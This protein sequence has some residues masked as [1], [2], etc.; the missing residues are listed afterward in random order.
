MKVESSTPAASSAAT[1]P[2]T[3]SSTASSA[4]H[5]R[6]ITSSRWSACGREPARHGHTRSPS[7]GVTAGGALPVIMS[8]TGPREPHDYRDY[9]LWVPDN[10][11]QPPP[12]KR[13]GGERKG[14]RQSQSVC[15]WGVEAN[16]RNLGNESY[17]IG[18]QCEI[19]GH[20]WRFACDDT[21]RPNHRI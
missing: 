21:N 17:V 2:S 15:L 14:K 5:R 1:T 6:R 8:I 18:R 16:V 19:C 11:I 13:G 9:N 20:P 12:K 10:L 3:R 7:Y 4:P